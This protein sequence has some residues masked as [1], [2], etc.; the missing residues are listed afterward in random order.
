MKQL[1]WAKHRFER[2]VVKAKKALSSGNLLSAVVWAQIGAHFARRRH[3]GFYTSMVLESLLLEVANRV[4]SRTVT[5][6][7]GPWVR[8]KYNNMGKAHVLHVMTSPYRSGGPRPIV[9]AWIRNTADTAVH[10]LLTTTQLGTLPDGLAS[11]IGATGGWYRPLAA[12]S[13]N[14]SIVLSCYDRSAEIGR[15]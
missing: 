2:T 9:E 15:M 8:S 11:S 4:D 3:P 10:S 13:S 5:L 6:P 1:S 12:L 7:M 14:Y